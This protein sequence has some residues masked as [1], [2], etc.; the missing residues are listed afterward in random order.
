MNDFKQRTMDHGISQ[1]PLLGIHGF[2]PSTVRWC[3]MHVLHLGL[4]FVCNGSGMK[5]GR[6][7]SN[8]LNYICM[9]FFWGGS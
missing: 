4:L 3:M 7:L 6:I 9:I 2:Q 8:I 1:G 5:F